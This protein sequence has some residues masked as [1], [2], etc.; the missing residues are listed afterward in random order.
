MPPTSFAES[1]HQCGL[2]FWENHKP[3][4]E[5]RPKAISIYTGVRAL[6]RLAALSAGQCRIFVSSGNEDSFLVRTRERISCSD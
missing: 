6:L 5:K 2:T 1:G 4:W 3:L